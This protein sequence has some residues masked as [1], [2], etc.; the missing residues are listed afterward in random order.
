M[1]DDG[2][3]EDAVAEPQR[4][5]DDEHRPKVSGALDDDGKRRLGAVKQRILQE[6]VLDRVAGQA[7]LGED[8]HGDAVRG[9]L[10]RL[11]STASALAGGSAAASGDVHAA[12]RAKPCS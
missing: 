4:R 5:P 9:T 7:E 11:R 10:A 2:A 8:S 3:V 12:T 6:Q 1:D